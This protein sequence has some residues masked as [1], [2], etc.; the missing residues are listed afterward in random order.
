VSSDA[1]DSDESPKVNDRRRIDPLTGL[2]RADQEP[3]GGSSADEDADRLDAEL[4]DLEAGL[5][6]DLV[7]LQ[8]DLAERT[9]DLQRLHAEYANY[10]KR[11]ERDRDGVREQAIAGVL[12]E[13]LPLLDD[14]GRAREHGE[15]DGALKAIG[16]SL[17]SAVA[18]LGLEPFGAVGDPF[19]PMIHEALTHEHSGDV[20]EATCIGIF[21]PGYRYRDR[22]VRPVRVAVAEPE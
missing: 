15:F 18:R 22:V 12:T 17:E 13:L 10:R 8:G 14:V 16:E 20:S 7:A 19:D 11:V 2:V 6:G 21:Q 1:S 5:A 4:T 9:A 3:T